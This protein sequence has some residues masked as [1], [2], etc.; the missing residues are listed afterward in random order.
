M[1]YTGAIYVIPDGTKDRRIKVDF[2][3]VW[4]IQI[5]YNIDGYEAVV[6]YLREKYKKLFYRMGHEI[7]DK[8]YSDYRP[9]EQSMYDMVIYDWM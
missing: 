3:K 5:R 2:E 9:Y 7:F 4:S 6:Q 1:N 8:I